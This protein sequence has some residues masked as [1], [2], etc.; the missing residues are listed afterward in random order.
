MNDINGIS[1]QTPQLPP[2]SGT[3]PKNRP[4]NLQTVV[5]EKKNF[6]L[7]NYKTKKTMRIL[8]SFY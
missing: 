5:N 3:I 8:I 1:T 2:E 7:K 4:P 6:H